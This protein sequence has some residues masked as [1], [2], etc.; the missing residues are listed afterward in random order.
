MA[1]GIIFAI[2]FIAI[3][4][5]LAV[6]GFIGE[7]DGWLGRALVIGIIVCALALIIVPFSWHTIN[8]GEVAVVKHLGKI[9]EA[10]IQ[11]ALDTVIHSEN[12]FDILV[13]K[14]TANNTAERCVYC[15]S[16]SAGLSDDSISLQYHRNL[17]SL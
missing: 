15:G 3:I 2:I 4:V 16:R 5:G 8:S 10:V 11:N 13:F 12:G 9:T 17:Q 14:R 1:I 7:P 6:V